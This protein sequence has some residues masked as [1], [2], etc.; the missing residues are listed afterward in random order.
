[1]EEPVASN[2]EIVVSFDRMNAIKSFNASDKIV[3][4]EPGLITADLQT[5]AKDQG[6]FYPVDFAQPAQ[7]RLEVMSLLTREE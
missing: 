6:F 3:T 4:C 5:F 2:G 7:V 1:M